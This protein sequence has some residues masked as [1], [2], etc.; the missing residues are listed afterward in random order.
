M[1]LMVAIAASTTS[2]GAHVA[3]IQPFCISA[4]KSKAGYACHRYLFASLTT[5]VYTFILNARLSLFYSETEPD[6]SMQLVAGIINDRYRGN[7][8]AIDTSSAPAYAL[9]S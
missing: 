8:V 1:L 2:F 9:C 4:G 7:G 5:G 3:G 6:Q